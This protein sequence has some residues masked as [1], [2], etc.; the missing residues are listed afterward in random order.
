MHGYNS[1]KSVDWSPQSQARR[2]RRQRRL[3]FEGLEDRAL[4]ASFAEVGSLLNL[5]LNVTN[6]AVGIASGGTSYTFTLTG[7]TWSGADSAHVT[8]NGTT[9][10][11]VT[12]AGLDHFDTLNITDSATGSAV[13][14]NDSGANA[15]SDNFIV[16]LDDDPA[17]DVGEQ[18]VVFNGAS[19]FGAFGL[20]VSTTRNIVLNSAASIATSSGGITFQAN[21]AATASS[22]K[23]AGI[24]VNNNATITS[25]DTGSIQLTGR[26]G[27]TSDFNYGVVL[28]SG[29]R[30]TGGS[31]GTAVSISGTGGSS[32]SNFGSMGIAVIG[33]STTIVTSL[34]GAVSLTGQGGGSGGGQSHVGVV[35]GGGQIT[36]G[37]TGTVTITGAGG[38]SGTGGSGSN[39]GIQVG[40][41]I[42][43]SGG[44]VEVIG[45]GGSGDSGLN[46]GVYVQG[47]QITSGGTGTVNVVGTA[48][49]GTVNGSRGVFVVSSGQIS[50][51]GSGNVTV[52][53][54]GGTG[55]AS[56]NVGVSVQDIGSAISSGSGVVSVTGQGGGSGT[57][58]QNYGI[59]VASGAQVTAGSNGA[60]SLMGTAASNNGSNNA[61]VRIDGSGSTVTS[62]GGAVSVTGLGR[63]AISGSGFGNSGVVVSNNGR[64]TA[65]SNGAVSVNGM[66]SA[67]GSGGNNHGVYVNANPG[68]SAI[69]SSGGDVQVIGQGGGSGFGNHGVFVDFNGQ[70]TAGGTGN[71]TVVGT[72]GSTGSSVGV[73]VAGNTFSSAIITSS[74]GSVRV[75]GQGGGAVVGTATHGV[76]VEVNGQITAGGTGTV[77]V[78]GTG[79]IGSSGNNQGVLVNGTS[80]T[81]AS[82]GGSVEVAGTAGAGSSPSSFAVRV[83]ASGTI[84][85]AFNGG[86]IILVGDSMDI[87]SSA[88]VN[89]GAN[90]ATLKPRTATGTLGINLGGADVTASTLGLT[91]AELD[92]ITAG[93]L[94][95]GNGTAGTITI[96]AAISRGTSTDLQL[97]TGGAG[98]IQFGAAGSL[99]A[100]GGNVTLTTGAGAGSGGV[101]GN[102]GGTTNVRANT[103]II[104]SGALGVA[105]GGGYLT[106]SV[107]SIA[108]SATGGAI[109]LKEVDDVA[110]VSPGLT[111]TTLLHLEGG[112]FVHSDNDLIDNGMHVD[113]RPG[114]TLDLN[115]FSDQVVG[116][117]VYG[118]M[119]GPAAA[120]LTGSG[121][122]ILGSNGISYGYFGSGAVGATIEGN[123]DMG[124]TV[125]AVDIPDGNSATDLTIAANIHNGGLRKTGSGTLALAGV[126]DY[127]GATTIDG[128]TLHVLGALHPS[129][130]VTV[131]AGTLS[132]NGAVG[133]VVVNSGGVLTPGVS[134]GVLASRSV[135]LNTGAIL[136]IELNGNQAGSDYD[137][138]TVSGSVALAG[139]LNVSLGYTPAPGQ[140]FVI[141]SN[142]GT[143]PVQGTFTGLS[144]DATFLVGSDLLQISYTGGD[145][146]DV[147]LV[148]RIA[149][150]N[151]VDSGPG[152]L[153]QALLNANSL[154]GQDEILFA[155]PGAGPHTI[156]PLSALPEITESVVIDGY[157]QAGSASNTSTVGTGAILMVELDGQLAGEDVHGLLFRNASSTVRGLVI[158]QFDG[159]G[160]A[161]FDGL[162][163]ADM[164]IEGNFIGTDVTGLL[165]R[166]NHSDGIRVES[167]SSGSV[168]IGGSSPA[169]RNVISASTG[170]NYMGQ[171]GS[172]G[173]GIYA[174]Q[175]TNLIVLGNFIG[176]DKTGNESLG[177]ASDGIKVTFSEA[178]R[179]GG[180]ESGDG[181]LIS[182]NAASYG[183]MLAATTDVVIQSNRIGVNALGTAALPNGHGIFGYYAN[184]T[185]I[186]GTESAAGN[187][188]SGNGTG[189]TLQ[190]S[191]SAVMQGNW[192]GIDAT[193]SLPI[194]NGIGV[195][196]F[197]TAQC[198][199]GGTVPEASNVISGNSYYGIELRQPA[200]IG[201]RVQG[202]RVGTDAAG[203][204]ALGNGW[205]G[206]FIWEGA[207]HNLIGGT[208]A[209]A[210]NTIAF[211]TLNGVH[212]ASTGTDASTGNTIARNA[213][214]GNAFGIDLASDGVSPNDAGD[215]DAGPN[216]LQN[217]PVLTLARAGTNTLV[218][219]TLNSVPDATFTLDFYANTTLD[220]SGNGQ[221]KRYLGSLPLTTDAFGNVSF[222]TALAV[223]TTPGEFLTATATDSS[224]NT[225]EFSRAAAVTIGNQ[226]P[227]ITSNGGGESAGL[228]V[229]ENS[230]AVTTA[231]AT[232]P[233]AGQTLTYGISGGPDAARF[234]MDGSSGVLA[235]A[236]APDFE[237]PMDV[238]GNNVYDVIVQVS[239]GSG[240][241]DTQAI[242]I[243]VTNVNDFVP[244]AA[245]P[246]FTTTGNVPFSDGVSA[247]DGDV[248]PLLFMLLAPPAHGQLSFAA[249]GTFTYTP[250]VAFTGSDTFSFQAS[251]GTF[252]SNV[253]QVTIN[254][255]S[256]A[257]TVA[258]TS[259]K[260]QVVEE[261]GRVSFT[262]RLSEVS[263]QNVTIPLTISGS[264]PPSDYSLPNGTTLIIPAGAATGTLSFDIVNDTNAELAKTVVFTM[265]APL[266][267]VRN[268]PPLT[269][270]VT[271]QAN[272]APSAS[273]VQSEYIF[274]ERS[275]NY[276]QVQVYDSNCNCYFYQTL[277]D[278]FDYV[279]VNAKLSKAVNYD[280]YV[281]FSYAGDVDSF[282]YSL[283][284]GDYAFVV[285]PVLGF[286]TPHVKFAAGSVA[287]SLVFRIEDDL[288]IEKTETLKIQMWEPGDES[289]ILGTTPITAVRIPDNDYPKL[290]FS[291]S[292]QVVW[293]D[294]GSAIVTVAL[295]RI[296]PTP[297]SFEVR[298]QGGTA[299]IGSDVTV[300][301]NIFTIPI[302]ATSVGIPVNI[303][304]DSA[305][306]SSTPETIQLALLNITGAELD[307]TV[308]SHTI[309]IYD[310]DPTVQWVGGGSTMEWAAFDLN[311]YATLS[312]PTNKD[313]TV[314]Y[315][316]SGSATK[317]SQYDYTVSPSSSP[318]IIRA[319]EDRRALTFNLIN[320]TRVEPKETIT[321]TMG[322]VTNATKVGTASD[323]LTIIDDDLPSIQ[324][325]GSSASVKESGGAVTV[326]V[327]L[328]AAASSD[329]EVAVRVGGTAADGF[330]YSISGLSALPS[331]LGGIGVIIPA[332]QTSKTFTVTPKD[333]LRRNADQTVILTL[334]SA[335]HAVKGANTKYTITIKDDDAAPSTIKVGGKTFVV[336]HGYIVGGTAFFDANKNLILDFLDLNGDGVQDV[337]EPTEVST[338]SGNDGFF[339]L[340]VPLDFD[341]SGDGV[342]DVS[343]GQY[344]VVGGIDTSTMRVP[345]APLVAPVGTY[346]ITP[347][348]TLVATLVN[349][350]GFGV[351]AAY[352][353]VLKA[354]GLPDIDITQFDVPRDVAAGHPDVPALFAA[355]TKLFNALSEVAGFISGAETGP[356]ADFLASAVMSNLAAKITEPD[357]YLDLSNST[358]VESVIQGVL[359]ETGVV[360]TPEAVSGAAAVVAEGNQQIDLVPI[361]GDATF[362]GRIAQIQIVAEGT[363]TQQLHAVAAG[364][365]TL[366]E[367]IQNNT[368]RA[369]LDQISTAVIG[370]VLPTGIII[371]DVRQAEGDA[372]QTFFDFTVALDRPSSQAITVNYATQDG[373]AEVA[374]GDYDPT[375]G[376]LTWAPGDDAPQIIRVAVFGD[377]RFEVGEDFFVVL[378]DPT[379][380]VARKDIGQGIVAND[381]GFT[382][383]AP[384]DAGANILKL[385]VDGQFVELFR[386]EE[387]VIQGDLPKDALFNVLGADGVENNL[388]V[389]LGNRTPTSGIVSFSGA[390]GMNY[391]TVQDASAESVVHTLSGSRSGNLAIDGLMLQYNNIDMVTDG[392]APALTGLPASSVEGTEIVFDI[393]APEDDAPE[394]FSYHWIVKRNGAEHATGAGEE[395]RF[396]P[397]GD[398]NY[399]VSVTILAEGRGLGTVAGTFHVDNLPPS[400]AAGNATVTVDEGH[401]A[402]NVGTFRDLDPVTLSASVGAVTDN[403][404]GSWAWD[405]I[406]DDGPTDSQTV[407]ITATDVDGES[408]STSF[409][410]ILNNVAPTVSIA[411]PTS[412]VR[413][414]TM[415]FTL[416]AQDPSPAD[417]SAG[418]TFDI[419]WDGD[420]I[421]EQTVQ[422]PS[423]TQVTH[424][425][426]RN[427]NV[428]I[429]VGGRDK[430][431][432]VGVTAHAVAVAIAAL[433]DDPLSPGTQMLVVGGSGGSDSIRI[434]TDSDDDH[435][436]PEAEYIKILINERDEVRH[437]I[438]GTFAL[439]VS[440]VV[441]YAQAGNDDVKMNDDDTIAVWFY[442]GDGNDRLKG[443]AGHD[444]LFG[445]NGDDFLAGGNG[446]DWLVGGNGADRIVGYAGDDILIAGTTDYDARAAVIALIMQEWTRTD[447]TF[448]SRISHLASGGGLNGPHRLTDD[449]VH[450]DHAEDI[451]TGSSGNDWFMFN[452]DGDGQIKD[453]ATDLST[454]ELQYAEDIDW[455]NQ[456]L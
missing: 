191:V 338:L 45:Q 226:P 344:V 190:D 129:S 242:S 108:V 270:T 175:A 401:I 350:Q 65:G 168:T 372:G 422:G 29:S 9:S 217:Y 311:M 128:G 126:N 409:D 183:I 239:D 280:V 213:I 300:P 227:A 330:D 33:N 440:R 43:S 319:G 255:L 13:K 135:A 152:S 83:L 448:A 91:D 381:D 206:V 316:I 302:G 148:T 205:A 291:R 395:F 90:T 295:N 120:L 177:N 201:N 433:Q 204:G 123:L 385:H 398:A 107:A 162:D 327:E 20:D 85:T 209:G 221:G 418:F 339:A 353:R 323:T 278:P 366:D 241:I 243:A 21:T 119:S 98:E 53:G 197:N 155:I 412:A 436:D 304:N 125:R 102:L 18:S 424:I 77:T 89:A 173:N 432:G 314:N 181:N 154:V 215:S 331:N 294:A 266:N 396:T 44:A 442:G 210:G 167:T 444:V 100:T 93:T 105:A 377:G 445:E 362:L 378:T 62:S 67:S 69:A 158:N 287:A 59:L 441:V 165:P 214:Y 76:D 334:G 144:Q 246:T 238:G 186:G 39:Y 276:R 1:K 79:G 25:S 329:A 340:D 430:D 8:G 437:K 363:V 394:R 379:N 203:T 248:D 5:D 96:S 449:T 352:Q 285:D 134:A 174:A 225:S 317:G 253:A 17:V 124:G 368:G 84:S 63:A 88:A 68:T 403:G 386:G 296:A 273:F 36:A 164:R 57:G 42:T 16:T 400:I 399:D 324:F 14:F 297:V 348:T 51:G 143:D 122:L 71:V 264:A 236:S 60:V 230:T 139:N 159:A 293:E 343:E 416:N 52:T 320:D 137:Q 211:N 4:L 189:I 349:E 443:G 303:F 171:N 370:D 383:Q 180:A 272:D 229:L 405:Y 192:I 150:T 289:A 435:E 37:G 369:L 24:T 48:G 439:P 95:I 61:G 269:H 27:T 408:R 58:G 306:E 389:E 290:R 262:A 413:G 263:G 373:T 358:V 425:F 64:I 265:G 252:T 219:G 411:S 232:D 341:T 207:S 130:T 11:I 231:T 15:Y 12:T 184:G 421:V 224:G 237:S 271:I 87:D 351:D 172:A 7:D 275:S 182:G 176:T 404:D 322:A 359:N 233:D 332:G 455:I 406:P 309:Q 336:S 86:A 50:S 10:L 195:S 26:G 109:R 35:V 131:N 279:S 117:N 156:Q 157:T 218:G 66:G 23:F 361:S 257:P 367:F 283:S 256:G 149:V 390:G 337:D 384:A 106:T 299:S 198:V 22:G 428:T 151:V 178:T 142:D 169:A 438:R 434:R 138:L 188:I 208:A 342:I 364:T 312:Y 153:R 6:T 274:S 40:A 360:M 321:V 187:L 391:L 94:L 277:S 244:V 375:S 115:G 453:K 387:T 388:T 145:G 305:S 41:K 356:P 307:G 228:S 392:M 347:L 179:I 30:V 371:A 2:R 80:S 112:H 46:Y 346:S 31:V 161:V 310:D 99:D 199:I 414:Q 402:T 166:G 292:S 365:L 140:R 288:L 55:S 136:G 49:N 245:N 47:G 335:Y 116:V 452:R 81:I 313:V 127:V 420:G 235:F 194:P 268:S 284:S 456:S 301:G 104:N 193:G 382:Y 410:L 196:L 308:P 200:T 357:S 74:G 286:P 54:T 254:D 220:A 97:I 281:P 258:F 82:N 32:N 415:T 247:T 28:N 417:Q 450:D 121:T 345:V 260:Q 38:N 132:G 431:G 185:R 163:G 454:F 380:A 72:G 354:L 92:R 133:N 326:T 447:A 355:S 141:I 118:T 146:N 328:S 429:K 114:A 333:N 393:V 34:G 318:L 3:L 19:N 110:I 75:T 315:S 249:D 56:A 251:D 103:L 261:I 451:L 427:D 282:D 250:N 325:S 222:N 298:R 101:K 407:T 170:A 240:D 147:E 78:E 70:I 374:G 160:I 446:R 73:K 216:D 397:D 212:V 259:D 113:L 376:V 423:G 426:T 223:A 419:D 234:T 202:N 267:A 111:G